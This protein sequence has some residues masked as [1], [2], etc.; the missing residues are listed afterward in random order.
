MAFIFNSA[1]IM[2]T[3]LTICLLLLVLGVFSVQGKNLAQQDKAK[4]KFSSVST[5]IKC[6]DSCPFK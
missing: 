2:D 6:F 5:G 3:K 1:P 4:R